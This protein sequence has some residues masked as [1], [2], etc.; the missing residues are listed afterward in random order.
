MLSQL[1]Q[2]ASEEKG[3]T[4]NYHRG[5]SYH[6][7]LREPENSRW[8]I[9]ESRERLYKTYGDNLADAP[10]AS[11]STLNL[12]QRVMEAASRPL[13]NSEPDLLRNPSN[14]APLVPKTNPETP[15]LAQRRTMGSFGRSS[16]TSLN[17]RKSDQ[18]SAPK[19]RSVSRAASKVAMLERAS[20]VKSLKGE[21]GNVGSRTSSRLEGRA[22]PR[23][24]SMERIAEA[25]QKAASRR[26]SA[27]TVDEN[28]GS[29]RNIPHG[30]LFLPSS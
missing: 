4:S 18:N 26:E 11:R 10:W 23:P 6:D 2:I 20:S 29:R 17:S 30:A 21:K 28:L 25:V 3:R 27:R 15:P 8:P 16:T 19:S 1:I 13:P 24:E 22:P 12:T 9:S 14:E 5:L 7:G